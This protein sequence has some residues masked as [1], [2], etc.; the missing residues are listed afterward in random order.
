MQSSTCD[1]HVT[2]HRVGTVEIL[3]PCFPGLFL[4]QW[5]FYTIFSCWFLLF[6]YVAWVCILGCFPGSPLSLYTHTPDD[7]ILHG[8]NYPQLADNSLIYLSSPALS[9]DSNCLMLSLL[10]ILMYS[11]NVIHPKWNFWLLSIPTLAGNLPCCRKWYHPPPSYL[12]EKS[13]V[14]SF[15]SLPS[16]IHQ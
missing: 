3:I 2:M 6:L 7:L 12:K 5:I 8:F 9:P 10:G 14:P 16:Q 4:L 11:S 1:L 13:R 15:P